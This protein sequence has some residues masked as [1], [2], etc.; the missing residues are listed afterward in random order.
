MMGT[1]S[2]L[3]AIV[4]QSFGRVIDCEFNLTTLIFMIVAD[5]SLLCEQFLHP[6]DLMY[7]DSPTICPGVESASALVF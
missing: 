4:G 3:D 6:H 2:L 5:S 7:I 1:G